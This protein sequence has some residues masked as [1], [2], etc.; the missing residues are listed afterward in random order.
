M[1]VGFEASDLGIERLTGLPQCHDFA[2]ELSKIQVDFSLVMVNGLRQAASAENSRCLSKSTLFHHIMLRSI[3]FNYIILCYVIL[4]H[5][6]FYSIPL[7]YILVYSILFYSMLFYS[8]L[9]YYIT[10]YSIL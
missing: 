4:Y 5:I 9:F 1:L 7:Y 6:L 8:I 3:L 2:E 10:L